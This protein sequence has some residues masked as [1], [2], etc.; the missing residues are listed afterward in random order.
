MSISA[1]R[2]VA[3]IYTYSGAT[4]AGYASGAY[5]TDGTLYFCRVVERAS[6]ERMATGQ[7]DGATS[8]VLE[9]GDEIVVDLTSIFWVDGLTYR[10]VGVTRRPLRRVNQYA[11]EWIDQP[12][13][14]TES[15]A[16]GAWPLDGTRKLN[17]LNPSLLT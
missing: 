11:I 17:G 9:L 16:N 7:I 6:R 8:A 5:V 2:Q 1:R 14:L 13:D 10:I 12:V 15:L 4:A 3:R